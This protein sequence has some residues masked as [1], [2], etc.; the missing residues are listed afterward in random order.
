MALRADHR[1]HVLRVEDSRRAHNC[2]WTNIE[3]GIEPPDQSTP[4]LPDAERDRKPLALI[5]G[6]V[7]YPNGWVLNPAHDLDSAITAPVADHDE[8]EGAP[9]ARFEDTNDR[10]Q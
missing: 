7:K 4:R 5:S 8:L 2:L 1:I 6:V 10:P 9:E 3:I